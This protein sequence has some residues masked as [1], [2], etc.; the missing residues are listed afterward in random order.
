MRSRL[1]LLVFVTRFA[2]TII[3]RFRLLTPVPETGA[4]PTA[5]HLEI[6]SFVESGGDLC[7]HKCEIILRVSCD[8]Y[9][10]GALYLALA[11]ANALAE[12]SARTHLQ[13]SLQMR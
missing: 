5:L 2:Q 9:C 8:A 6:L 10:V 1:W 4:L 3:N 12:Q 13:A 7:S 11:Q